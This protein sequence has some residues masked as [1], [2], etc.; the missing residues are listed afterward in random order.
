MEYVCLFCNRK[1]KR[2][3]DL[4][5]HK[6]FCHNDK[7]SK[8]YL[9]HKKFCPKC[10]SEFV[11]NTKFCSRACANSHFV[12]EEH[13]RKTSETLKSKNNK[14]PKRKCSNCGKEISNKNKS[15]FCQECSRH[16]RLVSNETKEKLSIAGKKSANIQRE[17]RRSKNEIYFS[18]LL[19]EN[20]FEIKCNESMF[21]GWD[22]DIILPSKKVAILWNGNWHYKDICGQLNQV[23]NRDKIKYKEIVKCGYMPYVITDLGKFSKVKCEKEFLRFKDFLSII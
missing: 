17:N 11:A 19:I 6:D 13:K 10:G 1:F 12:S 14:K 20:N 18:N 15:G 9:A 8:W 2:K 7:N 22:A 16:Y 4:T 5:Q 3:E 21:N 23:Q